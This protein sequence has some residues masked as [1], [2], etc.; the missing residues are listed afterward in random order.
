MTCGL[1]YFCTEL[2]V[3]PMTSGKTQLNKKTCLKKQTVDLV[4]K[5]K[6]KRDVSF[7]IPLYFKEIQFFRYLNALFVY[8]N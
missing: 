4:V 3:D 6:L 5:L 7:N 1:V 2:V 8:I